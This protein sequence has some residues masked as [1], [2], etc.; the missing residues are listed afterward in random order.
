MNR[1]PHSHHQSTPAALRIAV[2]AANNNNNNKNNTNT[3]NTTNNNTN[4]NNN[5]VTCMQTTCPFQLDPPA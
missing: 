5:A 3:T 4:N 1:M 2:Q